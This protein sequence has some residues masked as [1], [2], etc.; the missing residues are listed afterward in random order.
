M[1]IGAIAALCVITAA[2]II[3]GLILRAQERKR[4][5]AFQKARS[6]VSIREQY[7]RFYSSYQFE[8]V[9]ELLNKIAKLYGVKEAA[10]RPDDRFNVELRSLNLA[11]ADVKYEI[12][13]S[14]YRKGRSRAGKTTTSYPTT[15]ADY[16]EGILSADNLTGRPA[17][18]EG[19]PHTIAHKVKAS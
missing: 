17:S 1:N 11:H 13:C 15:V 5:R 6:D 14:T 10:L 12:I 7:E 4:I 16:I 3:G 19:V 18:H 8:Q 9:A 2:G